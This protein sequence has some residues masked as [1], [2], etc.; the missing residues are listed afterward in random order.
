M[1]PSRKCNC[2]SCERCKHREYMRGYYYSS[3]ASGGWEDRQCEWCGE[4]FRCTTR[5]A[6]GHGRK[7]CSRE[8]KAA[9]RATFQMLGRRLVLPTRECLFCGEA[10][11]ALRADARYCS[12]DH[13]HKAHQLKRGNGR[14]PRGSGRRREILRAYI[15][16]RDNSICHLC[17]K[18][19]KPSEI[20]LDHV[21]PL[22]QGGNHHE[23]NL[24]VA[25][26][27]CNA[28]KRDRPANEQ[29][30]AFG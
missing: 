19:A 20:Q 29:L 24:R 9:C 21:I 11:L 7:F 27:S 6:T 23:S 3:G 10:F 13:N 28:S 30:L 16:A 2:G 14:L 22:A 1:P 5:K 8:C 18:K 26:Q 17:G 25:H 15:I 12:A 4:K